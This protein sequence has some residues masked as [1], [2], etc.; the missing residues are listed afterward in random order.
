MA[1]LD[2][3]DRQRLNSWAAAV[4]A[5][6][7]RAL[8]DVLSTF[9]FEPAAHTIGPPASEADLATLR[10]RQPWIP[11]DLL[12]VCASVG[13]VDLPDIANGYLMFDAQYI[14]AMPEPDAGVPD[15]IGEPFDDPVDVVVFGSDG[16]G[17]LYAVAVGPAGTVYRLRE[18]GYLDGTYFSSGGAGVTVVAEHLAGFLDELLAAVAAFAVDGSITGL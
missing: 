3:V 2:D 12:A 4:D 6:A 17:A 16:G 8:R 1:T 9:P 18:C 10:S 15:R 7:T 5:A 13:A 14:L 11:D